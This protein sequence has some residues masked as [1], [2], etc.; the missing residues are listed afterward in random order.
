MEPRSSSR[1]QGKQSGGQSGAIQQGTLG[2]DSQA[3]RCPPCVHDSIPGGHP[4][5]KKTCPW[6]GPDPSSPEHLEM[7]TQ[8]GCCSA[9]PPCQKARM[10]PCPIDQCPDCLAQWALSR[11]TNLWTTQQH[12][13]LKSNRPAYAGS[14]IRVLDTWS[15][16]WQQIVNPAHT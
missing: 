14:M 12:G 3:E 4:R 6:R 1:Q 10:S 8:C 2:N 16:Q 7:C 5:K 15:P 11:W 13:G 9:S